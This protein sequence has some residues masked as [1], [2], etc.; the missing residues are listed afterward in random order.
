MTTKTRKKMPADPLSLKGFPRVF[1]DEWM[2]DHKGGPAYI[3]AGRHVKTMDAANACASRLLR[4][5]KVQDYI[6]A[7]ELELQAKLGITHERWLQEVALVAFSD[8]GEVANFDGKQ[9][10]FK[11]ITAI[12]EGARKAIQSITSREGIQGSSRSIKLWPKDVALQQLGE[13]LGMMKPD[14]GAGKGEIVRI[15]ADK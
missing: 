1:A 5:A 9:L 8:I 3:R 15:I 12:P 7:R 11:D 2:K 4:N 13:H 14:P 6:S 10:M